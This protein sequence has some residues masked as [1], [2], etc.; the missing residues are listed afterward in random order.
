[1]RLLERG[2]EL[3]QSARAEGVRLGVVEAVVQRD[4]RCGAGAQ[5]Q[6][7]GAHLRV[8]DDLVGELDRLIEGQVESDVGIGV[9]MLS[10]MSQ[11]SCV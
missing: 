8:G 4:D 10:L 7:D 2:L 3:E 6:L 1:V 9:L 11:A 5:G